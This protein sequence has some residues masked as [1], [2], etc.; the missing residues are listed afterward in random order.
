MSGDVREWLASLKLDRYY[1]QFID[2]GYDDLSSLQN[3]TDD[4]L[5]AIGVTLAGHRKR[6]IAKSND[7]AGAVFTSGGGFA[8]SSSASASES[9]ASLTPVA[10][11]PRNAEWETPR[12]DSL[13]DEISSLDDVLGELNALSGESAPKPPTDWTTSSSNAPLDA[14][15]DLDKLL[16]EMKDFNPLAMPQQPP[17]KNLEKE[18]PN[19]FPTTPSPTATDT[20]GAKDVIVD[21]VD[22][23][24]EVKEQ[25]ALAAT[26]VF[27][28]AKTVE[29]SGNPVVL[30]NPKEKQASTVEIKERLAEI[31]SQLDQTTMSEAEKEEHLKEAR[32]R[33]AME[34]I[35]KASEQQIV[36]DVYTGDGPPTPVVVQENMTAS[37]VC[38]LAVTKNRQ[39]EL[40]NWVLVE[41]WT[42]L[43]LERPLE[44][45]EIVLSVYQSWPRCSNNRFLLREDV[46]KFDI[47]EHPVRYFPAH[48]AMTP[49]E[50]RTG[51]K[52]AERAKAIL[53][54]EFFTSSGRVPEIEGNLSFKDDKKTWKKAFFMLRSSGLYYS[55]K[56]RSHESRHLVCHVKF[57]GHTLFV[58]KDFKKEFK[59]PTDFVYALKPIHSQAHKD[60]RC[61]CT[62]DSDS[63]MSWVAGIRLAIFGL[64]LRENYQAAQRKMVKLKELQKQRA[65]EN[66]Q[67]PPPAPLPVVIPENLTPN[68]EKAMQPLVPPTATTG[69]SYSLSP[70]TP[71]P[72]LPPPRNELQNHSP[73]ITLSPRMQLQ[74]QPGIRTSPRSPRRTRATS[75]DEPHLEQPWYHGNLTR[76]EAVAKLVKH[77]N[78]DGL[79]LV[80]ESTRQDGH[81]VLSMIAE[82]KPRHFQIQPLESL[83][84]Q[85]SIDDGPLFPNVVLLIEHY[86]S[87]PDRLP[88]RLVKGAAR[89]IYRKKGE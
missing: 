7:Y 22:V 74:P 21:H 77:G 5:N 19:V 12:L 40:K 47:F 59:A 10:A 83:P 37:A 53:L 35:R 48:L 88:C 81:Y 9:G 51:S 16:Y 18:P 39:D 33:I 24:D 78:F 75:D 29:L 15:L 34:K 28:Q 86:M 54:K 80:R 6:L 30:I 56:G 25:E 55:T 2:N 38:F 79:F 3:L 65:E 31:K 41:Y 46:L 72:P 85:Y 17:P 1:D 62:E 11:T 60:I 71:P 23:E 82:G 43:H 49:G 27:A 63:H 45:H 42:D 70:K 58:G 13:A 32:M 73:P 8:S 44:D 50:T 69:N 26:Q 66:V 20:G 68:G 52:K 36:V 14:D 84:L 89:P 4:D 57:E 64:Q 87:T 67:E 76:E 61:L